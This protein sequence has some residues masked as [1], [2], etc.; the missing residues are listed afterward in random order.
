MHIPIAAKELQTFVNNL[1]YYL[2]RG[3]MQSRQ[4]SGSRYS[5][6]N[7]AATLPAKPVAAAGGVS[8]PCMK[9]SLAGIARCAQSLAYDKP[10]YR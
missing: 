2:I 3:Q 8:C 10:A 6:A 9:H 5:A 1:A 7:A 4:P